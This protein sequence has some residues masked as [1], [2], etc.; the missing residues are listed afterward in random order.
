MSHSPRTLDSFFTEMCQEHDFCRV[1]LIRMDVEG[2]EVQILEGAKNTIKTFLP[3][4]FLELHVH[5][6]GI[7][8]ARILLRNLEETGYFVRQAIHRGIEYPL[9]GRPNDIMTD[10]KIEDLISSVPLSNLLLF[11]ENRNNS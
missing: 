2:A 10:M 4:I 6:I 7:S 8:R 9:V 11:L 3:K 5:S 1:D